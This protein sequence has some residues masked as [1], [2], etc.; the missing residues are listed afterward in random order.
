MSAFIDHFSTGDGRRLTKAIREI[1][2]KI[3]TKNNWIS[4][5]K[6]DKTVAFLAVPGVHP[7]PVGTLGGS[8]LP[9]KID[10]DLPGLGFTFHGASTNDHNPLRDEDLSRIAKA[11]VSASEE[12]EYSNSCTSTVYDGEIPAAYVTGIGEGKIIFA[13]PGDS[14]D[15]LPE[16]SARLERSSSNMTG[17]RIMIDLHNQEGWGVLPWQQVLKKEQCLKFLHLRHLSLALYQ[18]KGN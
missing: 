6:E 9:I 15:I 13:K 14:D 2:Q 1:C 18:K 3:E 10:P 7:G 5:R 4:I 11:M 8:N 16:L 12:A 17:R